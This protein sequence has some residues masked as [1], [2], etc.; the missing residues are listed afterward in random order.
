[1]LRRPTA[2]VADLFA[3]GLLLLLA[4]YTILPSELL[5]APELPFAIRVIAAR[6]IAV[7]AWL[8]LLGRWAEL[9]RD[10]FETTLRRLFWIGIASALLGA[11]LTPLLA[12]VWNGLWMKALLELKLGED[13]VRAIVNPSIGFPISFFL[14]DLPTSVIAWPGIR[15]LSTTVVEPLSA[16]FIFAMLFLV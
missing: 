5:D 15:R 8:Y 2:I 11:L 4:L 10:Q 6:S 1:M 14:P 3:L 16:G 7:L 12:S 13:T 9:S